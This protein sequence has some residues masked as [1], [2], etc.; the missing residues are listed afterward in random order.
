M[1]ITKYEHACVVIEDRGVRL[2]IDPGVFTTS[3]E[4]LTNICAVVVTHAHPDHF[5]P[6]LLDKIISQNPNAC[7][8]TTQEVALKVGNK[9][10]RV[11][12]EGMSED[13]NIFH[14]EFFGGKHAVIRPDIPQIE[15]IGVLVNDTFYY[16]GDS[17][18]IPDKRVNVLAV[19]AIA[20]WMKISEATEFI[21][22][23]GATTVFPT[24]NALLSD[25]GNQIYNPHL[26]S[27]AKAAGG[28]YVVITPGQS[29]EI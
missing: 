8:Y 14:I 20:P 3:L 18:A 5:D 2:V 29:V 11:V 10:Y 13:D 28:E 7:I 17:F 27:A 12:R 19:P 21:S 22:S 6:I 9:K 15:N 23:V 16:P 24:H 26:Q 4:D 25:I 1:K